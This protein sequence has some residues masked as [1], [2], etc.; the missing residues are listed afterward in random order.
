MSS[1]YVPAIAVT[2]PATVASPPGALSW[3]RL[4]WLIGSAVDAPSPTPPT[5][6]AKLG[7][8]RVFDRTGRYGGRR[9]GTSVIDAGGLSTIAPAWASSFTGVWELPWS[10]V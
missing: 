1:R 10:Q 4:D 2:S 8:S 3:L 7:P 9:G 5:T 6:A